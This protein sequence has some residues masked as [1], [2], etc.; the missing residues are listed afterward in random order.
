ME[1]AEQDTQNYSDQGQRSL[2]N[3]NILRKS[4]SIILY[5][6]L[7]IPHEKSAMRIQVKNT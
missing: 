7:F 2:N 4:N 6:L 1:E 3:S 5:F